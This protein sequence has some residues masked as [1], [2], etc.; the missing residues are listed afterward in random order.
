MTRCCHFFWP[1][2]LGLRC[3][4]CGQVSSIGADAL[5]MSSCWRLGFGWGRDDLVDLA[6]DVAFEAATA[7]RARG[8]LQGA[9]AAQGGEGCLAAQPIGVIASGDEQIENAL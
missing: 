4:E 8:C 7:G 2:Q 9:D 3:C 1:D 5:W 6:G